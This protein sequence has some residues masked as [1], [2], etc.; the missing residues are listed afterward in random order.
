[1]GAVRVQDGTR[2]MARGL[3]TARV[4]SL[5]D[6]TRQQGWRELRWQGQ[7]LEGQPHAWGSILEGHK[8]AGVGGPEMVGVGP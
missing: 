6:G 3:A 8:T 7:V 4:V 1:M 2:E 5:R